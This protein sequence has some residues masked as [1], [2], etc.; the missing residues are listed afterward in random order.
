VQRNP[1]VVFLV[2]MLG[3]ILGNLLADAFQGVPLLGKA[4]AMGLGPVTLDLYVLTLTL[5][6]SFKLTILGVVGV[7]VA[8][9]VM[10]RG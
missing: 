5:G 9:W 3:G 6:I 8:L 4:A 10:L 2:A 7:L 1:W